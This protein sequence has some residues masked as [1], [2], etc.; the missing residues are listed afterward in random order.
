MDDDD[1]DL[2]GSGGGGRGDDGWHAVA[3]HYHGGDGGGGGSQHFGGG[4]GSQ[5]HSQALPFLAHSQAGQGEPGEMDRVTA[6]LLESESCRAQI[7][8]ALQDPE[9]KKH[10]GVVIS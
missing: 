3:S 8:A 7:M 10:F 9:E 2:Y 5:S 1:D 4:G 6:A